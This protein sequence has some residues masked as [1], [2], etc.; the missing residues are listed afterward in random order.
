MKRILVC[1]DDV[2]ERA[3]LRSAIER[4]AHERRISNVVVAKTPSPQA[5]LNELMQAQNGLF[6][7]VICNMLGEG[8]LDALR[9]LRQLDPKLR[10]VLVSNRK[11]DA[12]T[13]YEIGATLLPVPIDGRGFEKAVGEPLC[14]IAARQSATI[15]VKTSSGL[16]NIPLEDVLFAE[17][18]KRGPI[19]H[20][21]N[22]ETVSARGSL[23]ALH[24]RLDRAD[25][26]RFVKVGSS[27]IVNLDNVR[28][29]GKGTLIFC[30]GEAIIVPVRM[31]T[32]LKE[33]LASYLRKPP[34]HEE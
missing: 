24:E 23:Q 33:T 20:L 18:A 7:M 15:T 30:D 5:M 17:S 31:R 3:L 32:S 29:F 28:S 14:D 2:A 10:I 6:D 1:D 26:K 11:P 16:S 19:I 8:T 25:G 22:G 12:V 13:A 21:P 34:N 27:F 4:F 9:R